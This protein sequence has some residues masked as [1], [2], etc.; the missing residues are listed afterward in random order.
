MMEKEKFE[1][2]KRFIPKLIG[3]WSVKNLVAEVYNLYQD[4][5]INEE[6]EDE[7]YKLVDPEDKEDS[8]AELWFNDY[9]CAELWDF[10][11]RGGI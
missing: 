7:L 8:P 10:V 2:L 3:K 11:E 4:Y 6:Q 1:V 9:G 5:L